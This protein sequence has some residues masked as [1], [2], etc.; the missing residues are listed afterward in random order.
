MI[1]EATQKALEAQRRKSLAKTRKEL[2]LALSRLT[3]NTP[4]VVAKGTKIT[5]AS[6]AKEAGIDRVT[7]YRY[8]EPVLVEIRK[9]NDSTPK[10][11]LKETRSELAETSSK[12]K[13][14]RKLVEEAQTEVVALAR[15]NYRLD[16]R[17][18]EMEEL[19]KLRDKVI[20][21]LQRQLNAPSSK[22]VAVSLL[23]HQGDS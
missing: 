10:V 8:H 12:L 3:K 4:R 5:A 16:A 14:Y 13:E 2:E 1:S 7:L 23:A 9:I 15:I 22:G 19:I 20:E 17:I 11:R 21:G 18:A 6:V